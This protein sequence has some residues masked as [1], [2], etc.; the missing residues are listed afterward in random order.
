MRY[1]DITVLNSDG[2]TF[3][4]WSSLNSLGQTNLGAQNVEI[5]MPVTAFNTPMGSSG[6]AV[7]V[8]G[9]SLD[10]ISNASDFNG[11]GIKVSGGMSRGL[12]LANPAQR[13]LLF[14]GQ[15]LQSWGN[16]IGTGMAL[17][18]NVIAGLV[19]QTAITAVNA[20]VQWRQGQPLSAAIDQLL[21]TAFPK[22]KTRSIS[23]S[24][25][26][27]VNHDETVSYGDLVQFSRWVNQ[28]SRSVIRDTAYQGVNVAFSGGGFNVYDGTVPTK[29]KDFSFLDL[30]GQPT[31]LTPFQVQALTVMRA[32]ISVGDSVTLP[33]G[34]QAI[35]PQGPGQ[36]KNRS[37]FTGKF[38][39]NQMRHAGIFRQV[40]AASWVTAFD[41]TAVQN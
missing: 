8:W 23:I 30:I 32:D 31:W 27:V 19:G 33:P 34:P 29:P 25:N 3:R 35:Q 1:Y 17:N 39:V 14:Q 22:V 20:S 28:Y 21:A 5:D 40:D 16:W 41:L 10:D 26:L 6:T 7:R 12:P 36:A 11:K 13:G 2:S 15:I 24:S 37:T 4:Q 18:F 9:I 38:L